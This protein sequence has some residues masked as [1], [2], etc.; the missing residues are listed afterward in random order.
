MQLLDNHTI[1]D[2]EIR[3]WDVQIYY[4]AEHPYLT[5]TVVGTDIAVFIGFEAEFPHGWE[6][7]PRPKILAAARKLAIQRLHEVISQRTRAR[8]RKWRQRGP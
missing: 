1:E 7:Q 4:P 6:E 5:A 3:G 2:V 8:R